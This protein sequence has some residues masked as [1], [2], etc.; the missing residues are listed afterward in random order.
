MVRRWAGSHGSACGSMREP[1]ASTREVGRRR[2]SVWWRGPVAAAKV[3]SMGA[4]TTR[5]LTARSCNDAVDGGVAVRGVGSARRTVV[6]L[7]SGDGPGGGS[8]CAD[9]SAG[10]ATDLVAAETAGGWGNLRSLRR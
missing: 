5:R 10:G 8:Y 3:A 7:L 1:G 6:R 4:A 9:G 2:L